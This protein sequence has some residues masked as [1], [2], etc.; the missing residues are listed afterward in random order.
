MK[1]AIRVIASAVFVLT[2]PIM[3]VGFA[4]S[5]VQDAIETGRSAYNDL[6]AWLWGV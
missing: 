5:L 2:L 3:A 4:S 1:F 6:G